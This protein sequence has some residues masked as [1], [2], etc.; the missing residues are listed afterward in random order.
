MIAS[1]WRL[2]LPVLRIGI[3]IEWAKNLKKK[4][5]K[6]ELF[7]YMAGIHSVEMLKYFSM[8]LIDLFSMLVTFSS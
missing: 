8:I 5:K 6:K 3:N 7:P 1:S 4:K 2:A